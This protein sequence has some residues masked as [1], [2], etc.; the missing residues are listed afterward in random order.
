MVPLEVAFIV[1]QQRRS[2]VVE[3]AK[4]MIPRLMAKPPRERM[5]QILHRLNNS[6]RSVFTSDS[7]QNK[8]Q[9]NIRPQPTAVGARILPQPVLQYGGDTPCVDVGTEGAWNL[10]E[11]QFFRPVTITSWAVASFPYA[12]DVDHPEGM[13]R[14]LEV[15]MQQMS[16][17]GCALPQGKPPVYYL[18]DAVRV[19]MDRNEMFANAR[20]L[21]FEAGKMA[22]QRYKRG[23]EILLV[24]LPTTSKDLYNAV[25]RATVSTSG[26]GVPSQ[27]FVAEK[28]GMGRPGGGR[29]GGR[30]GRGGG[31]GV[32][33]DYCANLAM[34]INVKMGG[35]VVALAGG[36]QVFPIIG[37]RPFMIIGAD[38][39][40][41]GPGNR[42]Q[43]SL[44][45]VVGSMDMFA[46]RYLQVMRPQGHR[47]AMIQE[48]GKMVKELCM[49]FYRVNR[50]VRPERLVIFRD[51]VSEGQQRMVLE[52]EY[53]DIRRELQ[54]LEAEYAPPITYVI[55]NKNHSVRLFP[56]ENSPDTVGRSQNVMPGTVVDGEITHPHHFDYYLVSHQGIQGTARPIHYTVILDENRFGSDAMQL[57]TYWM[58]YTFCRCTRSVSVVPPVYYA[59][60]V[61]KKG[62]GIQMREEMVTDSE[63]AVSDEDTQTIH[64]D[65]QQRMWYV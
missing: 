60:E 30:G 31:R 20:R 40:H 7:V 43:K 6:V 34:K 29:G 10:K 4:A 64:A 42:N 25:K 48:I 21:C 51:G 32:S 62:V 22:H 39:S 11:I 27:C 12:R 35:T 61:C 14:F 44:A 3:K 57:M 46:Q 5:D 24:C 49:Q 59:N 15:L 53:I 52:Q 13:D 63:S 41:P 55:V 36:P 33:P 2:N 28:A 9:I 23:P 50:D 37:N 38:V 65:L 1:D 19:G 54:S 16:N 8:W 45:A 58:T 47:I 18:P 56:E 26:L 17:C